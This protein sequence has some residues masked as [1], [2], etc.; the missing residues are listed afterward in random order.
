MKLANMPRVG[1]CVNG[2]LIKLNAPKTDE[3]HYVDRKGDHSLN[4]MMVAGPNFEFYYASC[5]WPGSVNDA[6]VLRCS[7]LYEKWNNG[8]RPFDNAILLGD[9]IYPLK[10]WLIPPMVFEQIT[11]ATEK[12]LQSNKCTRRI[13]E[14]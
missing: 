7:S 11:A 12:F 9:S 3:A 10:S 5:K 13:E 1:G 4:I 6:R 8:W 2:V 14:R